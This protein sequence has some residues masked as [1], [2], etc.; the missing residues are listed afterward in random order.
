[1]ALMAIILQLAN[2]KDM[3]FTATLMWI[4][5]PRQ[6]FGL[7]N[8]GKRFGRKM[9]SKVVQCTVCISMKQ[10]GAASCLEAQIH[11]LFSS[12]SP[13]NSTTPFFRCGSISRLYPRQ[14]VSGQSFG[15]EA[16]KPV[17]MRQ[18]TWDHDQGSRIK[19]HVIMSFDF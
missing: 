19:D 11:I 6:C 10:R 8:C 18:K 17:Y 14:S 13:Y 3:I 1:M 12:R 5:F 15:F 16:F 2:C 4:R 7:K 9:Q